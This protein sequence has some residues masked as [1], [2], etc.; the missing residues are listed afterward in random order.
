[1]ILNQEQINPFLKN[2]TYEC[3]FVRKRFAYT[4]FQEEISPYGNILS[5]KS[6]ITIGPL[7]LEDA[8]IFAVELPNA[9]SFG[10]VCFQRLYLAQLGSLLSQTIDRDCFVDENSLFISDKQASIGILNRVKN[11]VLLH[12]IFPIKTSQESLFVLKLEQECLNALQEQAIKAFQQMSKSIFLEI[13]R[14]NI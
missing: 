11:A 13:A 10:G 3:A 5:F 8:L 12:F 14:D 2:K 7:H 9:D 1:M 6:P 4:F